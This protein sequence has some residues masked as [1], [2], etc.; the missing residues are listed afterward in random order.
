[1][2]V[3]VAIDSFK[4]SISSIKGSEAIAL[5]IQEVYDNADIVTLPLADGEKELLMR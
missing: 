2:K 5:G 3:L 4:G 1:M